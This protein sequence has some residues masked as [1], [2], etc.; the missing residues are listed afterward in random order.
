MVPSRSGPH[1]VGIG[2][3][4]TRD[5]PDSLLPATIVSLFDDSVT[6]PDINKHFSIPDINK[7]FSGSVG[8]HP[9]VGRP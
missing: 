4:L 8:G 3:T 7:H 9:V 5:F 2:G 1:K 6:I